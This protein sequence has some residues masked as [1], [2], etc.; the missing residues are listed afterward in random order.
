MSDSQA[1]HC[2]IRPDEERVAE[3]TYASVFNIRINL[4]HLLPAERG[5]LYAKENYYR[6]TEEMDRSLTARKPSL[7]A[8]KTQANKRKRSSS[9]V[10]TKTSV[11]LTRDDGERSCTGFAIARSGNKLRILTCT[12]GMEEVYRAGKHIVT[13]ANLNTFYRFDVLC[14]HQEHW[15]VEKP[16]SKPIEKRDRLA[17]PG[18]VLA[19]DTEKDLMVLEVNLELLYCGWDKKGKG[20]VCSEDHPV[21]K[22]ATS[23]S[24]VFETIFLQGWPNQCYKSLSRG[25][26]S[27]EGRVYGALTQLN[28]KGYNMNLLEIIGM[29]GS[30][31]FSGGPVLNG[32]NE[33]LAVYHGVLESRGYAISL[34]DVIA[35]LDKFKM[36]AFPPEMRAS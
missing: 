17:A 34:R 24:R 20:I 36:L 1:Y 35:F 5:N 4:K 2:L 23:V 31:G 10:K 15:V 32:K 3:E 25:Q 18:Y 33:Y 12:H 13:A 27:F 30:E 21:L 26:M 6:I 19:I 9:R 29:L 7:K 8:R 28:Q 22:M 11:G 14:M 16:D